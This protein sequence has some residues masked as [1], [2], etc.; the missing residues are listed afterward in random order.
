MNKFTLLVEVPQGLGNLVYD[1]LHIENTLGHASDVVVG[2]DFVE[3]SSSSREDD[4]VLIIRVDTIAEALDSLGEPNI[5]IAVVTPD[6]TDNKM[7]V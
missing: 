4:T 6:D 5:A 3:T 1:G 7:L 2:D